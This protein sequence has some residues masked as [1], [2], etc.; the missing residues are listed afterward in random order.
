MYLSLLYSLRKVYIMF[1]YVSII[2]PVP[3]VNVSCVVVFP[4][5]VVKTFLFGSF[6]STPTFAA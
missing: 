2:F 4:T 6:Y 5:L 3:A 1:G